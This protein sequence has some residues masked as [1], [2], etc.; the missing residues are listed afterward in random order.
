MNHRNPF[1]KAY[2]PSSFLSGIDSSIGDEIIKKLADLVQVRVDD[3]TYPILYLDYQQLHLGDANYLLTRF[4]HLNA[5]LLVGEKSERI[6][7]KVTQDIWTAYFEII[8]GRPESLLTLHSLLEPLWIGSRLE[9]VPQDS[10]SPA[11]L[12][13]PKRSHITYYR[14]REC[15]D[16]CRIGFQGHYDYQEI[17]WTKKGILIRKHSL[18]S[19]DQSVAN[20]DTQ[21]LLEA[22]LIILGL[23]E[24]QA[25]FDLQHILEDLLVQAVFRRKYSAGYVAS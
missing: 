6:S 8:H 15:T 7:I 17:T 4:K 10:T 18:Q 3:T 13:G 22:A 9:R 20:S 24:D 25:Q 19:S 5:Q 21:L 14:S 2:D 16:Y 12:V 23:K 11:V 1:N